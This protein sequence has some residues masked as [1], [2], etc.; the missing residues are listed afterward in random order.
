[1]G[2]FIDKETVIDT[3]WL[4]TIDDHWQ[5]ANIHYSDAPSDTTEYVRKDGTWVPNSGGSGGEN[6]TSSNAGAGEGLALPKVGVDLPFKSL[7]AGSGITLIPAADSIAIEAS[8]VTGAIHADFTDDDHTQYH[9]DARGDARY[10]LQSQV[11]SSIATKIG[12]DDYATSTVG[13]T[14]KARH[15]PANNYLYLTNDGS[16]P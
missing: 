5:D 13:G 1:M 4:N 16:T 12:A 9:T 6:N 7:V 11:D 14:L 15:D 10:Y 3:P 2:K 8:G